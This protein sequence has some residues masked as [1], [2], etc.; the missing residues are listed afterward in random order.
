MEAW[1][2]ICKEEVLRM[3]EKKWKRVNKGGYILY[4]VTPYVYIE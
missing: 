3:K 2:D 1:V 4:V